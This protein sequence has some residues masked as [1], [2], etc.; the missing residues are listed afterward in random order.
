MPWTLKNPAAADIAPDWLQPYCTQFLRKLA[1]QGYARFTLRT[2]DRAAALFCSEVA[3][4]GLHSSQLVGTTL[5][6]VRAVALGKMHPNKYDEKKYCLDRFIDALVEAG[7]ARRPTPPRKASTPL[8]R[9]RSEYECYLRD[10][11]GLTDATIYHCAS[12]LNRFVVF[13]FGETL[14]NL[15]DITPHDIVDFLRKLRGGTAPRDKTAPSHLRNLFRFLFWSGKTKRDLA[16]S[17]PRAAQPPR[18]ALPRYL[19]PDEVE[20]LLDA[21]WAATPVGRRNYAMLMVLARLGLR[22]PEAIAIQLDDIDWRNGT[23]L[24][25]GKGKRHDR[26]PLPDEVGKAIVDYIKNGRRGSSRTLFVSSTPPHNPFVDAQILN[27]ALKQAFENTGIKPPQKYVGSHL[28]RHSLATEMLR[29]GASLDEIGDVLRHRSRMS[30]TIYARH[31]IDGLRSI[32]PA[33]PTEK[34]APRAA[35]GARA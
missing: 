34:V 18:S 31:D 20:K 27:T 22:A 24:I 28:L 26:M 1:D 4:R 35:K 12:F 6:K 2:Y 14:G 7:V 13:R 33:W 9:L 15:N 21:T 11:R 5:T 17:I 19:K 32:A 10:Q 16:A 29:K 3:R 30:T 25:R 8:D 23:I